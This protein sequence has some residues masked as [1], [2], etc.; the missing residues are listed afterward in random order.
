MLFRSVESGPVDEV[1]R[2]PKEDYTK[3]LIASRPGRKK[4]KGGGTDG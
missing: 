2:H 4:L 1:F 3:L